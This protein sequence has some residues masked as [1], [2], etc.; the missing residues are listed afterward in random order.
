MRRWLIWDLNQKNSCKI[1]SLYPYKGTYHYN[2]RLTFV[3][4]NFWFISQTVNLTAQPDN[5]W[6][7]IVIRGEC[8]LADISPCIFWWNHLNQFNMKK[9]WPLSQ[10]MY[11]NC[12]NTYWVANWMLHE[13][14]IRTEVSPDERRQLE[15]RAEKQQEAN[16]TYNHIT[17]QWH[18]SIVR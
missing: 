4:A 8:F 16:N 9:F 3:Y 6:P 11:Q 2:W 12:C 5:R 18:W 1:L 13:Y 14:S 15:I 7:R 10:L 17:G